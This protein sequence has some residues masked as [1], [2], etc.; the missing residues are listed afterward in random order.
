MKF[1]S[2][3]II[4]LLFNSLFIITIATA[5][6]EQAIQTQDN[7]NILQD[8]REA[9]NESDS[10]IGD[11]DAR[12]VAFKTATLGEGWIISS[13]NL[14]AESLRGFW[15]SRNYLNVSNSEIQGIIQRYGGDKEKTKEEIGKLS[16]KMLTNCFG[17]VYISSGKSFEKFK[18]VKK[19]IN[20][21]SASF[22]VIP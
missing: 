9:V 3:V 5:Q 22:Y 16:S 1:L 7:V 6:E 11:E 8:I 18:L 14:K 10:F 13:D 17:R 15:I 4:S 12:A 20:N 21:G 2:L 19:E